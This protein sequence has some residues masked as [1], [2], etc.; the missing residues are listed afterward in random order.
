[1]SN[2]SFFS[3]KRTSH[4]VLFLGYILIIF[5]IFPI[6]LGLFLSTLLSPILK[7]IYTTFKIPYV[8]V[9][10]GSSFLFFYGCYVAIVFSFN[11]LMV[12]LPQLQHFLTQDLF[13][14]PFLAT[15]STTS[16]H[17]IEQLSGFVVSTIQNIFHYIFELFLFLLAFYFSLFESKRNLY[18]F[19]AY[20]PAA[21]RTQWQQYYARA[22]QLF[23]TFLFVELRLLFLTFLLLAIG[24]FLLGFTYPLQKALFIAIA[25]CLPFFGIGIVLIPLAT[26]FYISDQLVL[27]VAIVLLYVF[28]QTTRQLTESYLWASTFHV[29]TIHTFMISAASV[30]LFG[31]YGIL[32]SPFLLLLAVKLKQQPIFGR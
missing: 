27:A 5:L 10:F 12:L 20:V 28:I 1:M 14:H 19:F 18:W 25:D 24:F 32:L 30:Y 11:S 23:T 17:W 7:W 2:L 16:M 21:V 31:F 8:F 15:I 4:F 26:Y 3:Y 22:M 13:E 6:S 29:R 9:V